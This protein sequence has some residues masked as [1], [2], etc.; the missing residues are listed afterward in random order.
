[1]QSQKGVQL[2]VLCGG[3]SV[4]TQ[5][6]IVPKAELTSTP[7]TYTT[8]SFR[9]PC[10]SPLT[11]II[12]RFTASNG[13]CQGGTCGNTIEISP[14]PLPVKFKSFTASRSKEKVAVKW[15]TATETNN[16]GFNV[17][18]KTNGDRENI[19][20]VFLQL[21]REIQLQI[22]LIHLMI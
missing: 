15:E 13:G 4:L 11:I 1:V 6:F 22:F 10:G 3:F 2:E 8:P 16:K 12:T 19:A 14:S 9:C 20:F 7:I 18:R 5:C 17:Q 21:R